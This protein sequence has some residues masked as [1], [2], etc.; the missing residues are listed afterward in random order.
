MAL[1]A[2]IGGSDVVGVLQAAADAGITISVERSESHL[3]DLAEPILTELCPEGHD[4]LPEPPL[5]DVPPGP[6]GDSAARTTWRK[7]WVLPP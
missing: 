3:D 4:S 2:R 1:L 7:L 5:D 6:R